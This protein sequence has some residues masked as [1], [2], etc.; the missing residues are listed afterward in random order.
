MPAAFKSI[1]QW[2][3][4]VGL[5]VFATG[6]VMLGK[7][8]TVLIERLRLQVN[9]AVGP[10][11]ELLSEPVDT[12]VNGI[13]RVQRWTNLNKEN[14]QLREDRDRLLRWQSVAQRLEVENVELRQLLNFVPE[15]EASFIS[16]RVVA[17]ST[18][19]FAQSLLLNAGSFAGV[20]KDQ[21]V[22]TG[23]GLVGRIIGVSQRASRVLLITD[24]SSKIPVFAGPS[25][26]RAVLA[27]DNTD[28]PKLTHIVGGEAIK[29]G[30]Q[31]V[32]SGIAGVFPPGLPVGVVDEV[33]EARISISPSVERDR[34]EYV[35]V[36]DYGIETIRVD[37]PMAAVKPREPQGVA[38][39]PSVRADAR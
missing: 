29:P 3:V 7:A 4:Y 5:V 17:D 18:G 13:A 36:V 6:V 8:D 34:L 22:L 11:L 35:R 15:P 32:T 16:A 26:V 1:V 21:L 38:G 39:K 28:R 10:I 24:I 25:R 14:A 33:D 23:E 37:P 31:V 27:G 9:D 20:E 19:A 30:D 2:L 12:L